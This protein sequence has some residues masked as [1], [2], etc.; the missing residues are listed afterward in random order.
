MSHPIAGT[1]AET[2]FRSRGITALHGTGS[3]RYH[4]RCYYRPDSYSEAETWPALI[5][6]VT[7]LDGQITGVHRTWLDP[8]G[9]DKAPIDTPRRAMGHLLGQGI[10]F[11]VASDT[12]AAGEGIETVLSLRMALPLMPM[13]AALSANHLAAVLFPPAVN[14]LYI[15]RDADTAGDCAVERLI[16]RAHEVG[17]HAIALSPRLSDFNEDLRRLGID[18]LRAALSVLLGPEDVARF[19]PWTSPGTDE[20]SAS[21]VGRRI[22]DRGDATLV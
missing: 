17:I 2:Y 10:R 12:M 14:R 11:G 19:M 21:Q 16:G 18:E 6:A 4:P 8:S 7:D 15:A 22:R 5:A 20:A 3:L 13:I 9:A 1:L